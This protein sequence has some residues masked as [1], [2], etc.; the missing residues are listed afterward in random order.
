MKLGLYR[1][2]LPF[3]EPINFNGTILS[4]RTG[5]LVNCD[6]GW[7]EICPLVNFSS[8]TL[9][10]AQEE[11]LDYLMNLKN[12]RKTYPVLPSVQ[13]GLDCMHSK[14]SYDDKFLERFHKDYT[15][16]LGSP[17]EITYQW[18]KYFGE[19]PLKVKLKVGRYNLKDE[20]RMIKEICKKSPNVKLILDSNCCWTREE[21]L[22]MMKHLNKD[23]I[24]YIEDPCKNLDDVEYVAKETD[25]P[26]AFDELVRTCGISEWQDFHNLK[27]V[28]IKPSLIGNFRMCEIIFNQAL[29][30]QIKVVFSS[31]FESQ[32]GNY[33]IK[34]F[35]LNNSSNCSNFHGLDT[36]KYFKYSVFKPNSLKINMNQ[37]TTLWEYT[38]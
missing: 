11:T 24:E 31:A 19:Y 29:M 34:M 9:E 1:Y 5:L 38:D 17:K 15:L 32:L 16:L 8:E 18:F 37:L 20:L 28:L 12:G 6:D 26:I 36:N 21:A 27:A 14:F 10:E 7:G 3:V 2:I 33:N 4:E 13:F 22:T 25:M 23:N 30:S 35:A